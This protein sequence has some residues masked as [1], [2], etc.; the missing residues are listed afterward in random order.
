[1][2]PLPSD[3]T[4]CLGEGSAGRI[5]I[6]RQQCRRYLELDRGMSRATSVAAHLCWDGRFVERI[7]AEDGE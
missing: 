4:R 5:C 7:Q 3:I 2:T 6:M 1:M